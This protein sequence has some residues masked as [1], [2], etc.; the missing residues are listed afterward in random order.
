MN[1]AQK[2]YDVHTLI[3][4]PVRLNLREIISLNHFHF[5]HASLKLLLSTSPCLLVSKRRNIVL[6]YELLWLCSR[7]VLDHAF[8]ALIRRCN[9]CWMF[10]H[11]HY[12]LVSRENCE[13][14]PSSGVVYRIKR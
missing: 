9:I 13:A 11:L 8:A 2:P 5:H 6:H 4:I 7:S 3:F 12:L 1:I 10:N 14:A